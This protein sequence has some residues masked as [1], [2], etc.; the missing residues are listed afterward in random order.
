MNRIQLVSGSLITLDL[1]NTKWRIQYGGHIN[2]INF[3]KPPP[4]QFLN[5]DS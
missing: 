2:L 5:P 1:K 4:R 3:Y